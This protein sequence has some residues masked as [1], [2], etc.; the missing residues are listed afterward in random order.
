MSSPV[1]PFFTKLDDVWD[2]HNIEGKQSKH[3]NRE[4]S[5]K[6][7][8]SSLVNG[9]FLMPKPTRLSDLISAMFCS[10]ERPLTSPKEFGHCSV[11]CYGSFF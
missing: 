1:A 7:L 10:F 2:K 5:G 9:K 3:I 8:G 6:A 4:A 11:N